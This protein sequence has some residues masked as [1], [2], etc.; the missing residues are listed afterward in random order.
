M[1]DSIEKFPQMEG[2]Y[3]VYAHINAPH[4]PYVFDEFGNYRYNEDPEKNLS[5]YKDTV[6]YLNKRVLE[7]VDN[8]I[9][10][11]EVP[12][13]IILQSDHAAHVIATA[14][15]KV[16]ILS[17]F[18]F[19]PEMQA[20]LYE[21]ITPVNTFRLILRDYFHQEIDLLPDKAFVKV[22][23]DHEYYPSACDM[24]VPAK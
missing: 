13:L 16:K 9:E 22:L 23:N 24:S 18:Y 3:F 4:G 10:D 15:D 12:P 17:A 14:Y 8:L 21:T 20:N 6:T 19:P 1:F 7:V 5:N 2:N 11:S